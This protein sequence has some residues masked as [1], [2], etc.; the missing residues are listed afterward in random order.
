MKPGDTV[1]C[2]FAGRIVWKKMSDVPE[3]VHHPDL[4]CVFV[5]YV[6]YL[7]R[8]GEDRHSDAMCYVCSKL[9]GCSYLT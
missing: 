4:G 2:E 1:L 8:H 6:W 3:F 9:Y 7:A 5:D